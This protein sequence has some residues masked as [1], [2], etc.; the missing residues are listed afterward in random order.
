MQGAEDGPFAVILA[1]TRELA[2]QIEEEA[3]KMAKFTEYRFVSVVGGQHSPCQCTPPFAPSPR[4]S[5]PHPLQYR[6]LMS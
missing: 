3:I 5:C 4:N 2:Q 6:C 1:P